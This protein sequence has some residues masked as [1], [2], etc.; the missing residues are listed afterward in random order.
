MN[1]SWH[2]LS[3]VLETVLRDFGSS[4]QD[5]VKLLTYPWCESPIHHITK[6]LCWIEIR[7]PRRLF[8]YNDL[9]VT[10]KKIVS[11]DLSFVTWHNIII[12]K[13]VHCDHKYSGRLWR[14]TDVQLLQS[15]SKCKKN[16]KAVWPFSSEL[17]HQQS[18]FNLRL[19]GYFLFGS[20]SVTCR[21]GC[22]GESQ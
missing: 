20:F 18:I 15:G 1:S 5:S 8:E 17:W 4:W 3:K 19:T 13:W 10:L 12:R 21:D 7:R 22:V 9:A 2:R 11:D 14:L 6:V 16:H